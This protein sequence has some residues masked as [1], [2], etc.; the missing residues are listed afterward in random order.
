MKKCFLVLLMLL[1]AGPAFAVTRYVDD[2][3][4]SGCSN[5]DTDYDPL[6]NNGAGGCGPSGT[7]NIYIGTTAIMTGLAALNAG[8]V[9]LIR[10]GPYT[11]NGIYGNAAGEDYGGGASSW[12]TA[13]RISNYPGETVTVDMTGDEFRIDSTQGYNATYIIWEGD[14]YDHFIFDGG[15][16]TTQAFII[17]NLASHIRLKNLT[18]RNFN[19]VGGITFGNGR[20]PS[21]GPQCTQKPLDIQIIGNLF[22]SNGNDVGDHGLYPSCS[23]NALVEYN[24]FRNNYQYGI[25]FNNSSGVLAHVSPTI[26]YNVC[27]GHEA[28]GDTSACIFVNRATN[29]VIYRNVLKG[30]G[31]G[32]QKYKRCIQTGTGVTGGLILHN[33]CYDFSVGAIQLGSTGSGWV[34]KNNIFDDV[35]ND[36]LETLGATVTTFDGNLCP[37]DDTSFGANGC[38]RITATPGFVS[39]G[40]D[41]TLAAGSSAIDAGV[42]HSGFTCNGACDIGAYETFTFASATVN[43]NILDVTLDMSLNTPVRVTTTGWSVR[44]GGVTRTVASAT[45]LTNSDS[46]VRVTFQGDP[47]EVGQTWDVSYSQTGTTTDSALIGGTANQELSAFTNQSA[48]NGC[49]SA[50]PADPGTPHI[51]YKLDEN[52][53]TTATDE[54]GNVN[55]TL[56]GTVTPSWV[57]GKH[58]SAV[59]FADLTDQRITVGYGNG[60][61]LTSQSLTICMGAFPLAGTES[62][63]YV[64]FGAPRGTNQ[65]FHIGRNGG[66]WGIGI[67]SSSHGVNADFPVAAGWAFL[68]V[69]ADSASDMATLYVNGVAGTSSE[70]VKSYSH[71]LAGNFE[72]GTLPTFLNGAVTVDEFRVYQSA[73]SASDIA[74]LYLAWEP[75]TPTP[76]G[77]YTQV[78]HQW[79][80]LRVPETDYGA[81]SATV[82]VIVGG[83]VSLVTQ[84]DC[85]GSDCD[86]TGLKL[87]YSCALCD[88]A[89]ELLP[90]PDVPSSDGVSFIG[91]AVDVDVLTSTVECCLSG[92]LTEN[93]GSTQLTASAV[94][95][96]DLAQ[97]ASFVRRSVLKFTTG[98]TAGRTYCFQEYHQTGVALATPTPSSGA[99]VTIASPS[100]GVGF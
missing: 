3:T 11:G 43:E 16:S 36:F 81:P 69:V 79:Q 94:P 97:D 15:N 70:S 57:T 26:R 33:T 80:L 47:C 50:P 66:T 14:S 67:G 40:S 8:D 61:D 63:N 20:G 93:D 29:P 96:I 39:A 89:G 12:E 71:T 37:I 41:F 1:L 34:I 27:E 24:I 84:V 35:P 92:S 48:T 90:V 99:C 77:T 44:V 68:C 22:F 95:L 100:I 82:S 17:D 46:V 23:E 7:A 13:T 53:G 30:L 73:L 2:T 38:D 5:P 56:T 42:A 4:P 59:S 85:T 87:Y 86:P 83:A 6:A 91:S 75:S 55:G 10:G 88:T 18:I 65:R 98:V 32:S 51:Y 9:L 60:V 25:H 62:A 52:T 19:E 49:G 74:D 76:T 58:G 78:A 45:K 21:G 54:Q 64:V 72:I 28:V 31:S